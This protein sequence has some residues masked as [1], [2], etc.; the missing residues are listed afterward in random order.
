MCLA[1]LAEWVRN[2]IL[3]VPLSTKSTH[4]YQRIELEQADNML[5]SNLRWTSIPLRGS[6]NTPSDGSDEPLWFL[7]TN[8]SRR[9]YL[10]LYIVG[11]VVVQ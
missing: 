1:E 7:R 2:F 3:V 6:S 5:V 9:T 10:I 11:Q 4:G 8:V